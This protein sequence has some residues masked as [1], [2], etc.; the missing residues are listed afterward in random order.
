MQNS[1]KEP[2]WIERLLVYCKALD[3]LSKVVNMSKQHPLNEYE[4]DSLIKRF[5]FSY[6]MAW[7][8]MMSYE[9]DNGFSELLGSKDVIRRAVSMSL[10]DNG[11]AWMDMI[12]VRN[13]TSHVYDEEMAIDVIDEIIYTLYPLFIELREKMTEIAN[14]NL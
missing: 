13:R 2:R 10:I 7:K 1:E 3:R 6:E 11:E 5:E 12:D 14:S 8:L 9:K 4:L